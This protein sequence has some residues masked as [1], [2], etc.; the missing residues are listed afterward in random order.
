MLVVQAR[1]QPLSG[2]HR[3]S[4]WTPWCRHDTC[5]DLLP[6]GPKPWHCWRRTAA[7]APQGTGK[8]LRGWRKVRHYSLSPEGQK[9]PLIPKEGQ[10][11]WGHLPTMQGLGQPEPEADQG[12]G[13]PTTTLPGQLDSASS[14]QE[15]QEHGELFWLR[16][17]AWNWK[18]S[19]NSEELPLLNQPHP[20]CKVMPEETEASAGLTASMATEP[21][22]APLPTRLI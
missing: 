10:S 2:V 8:N 9:V 14:E 17:K 22:P 4:E 13:L 5:L 1:R 6:Q 21:K 12:N 20:K 16:R 18:W 11:H 15:R 3:G 7:A 19:R